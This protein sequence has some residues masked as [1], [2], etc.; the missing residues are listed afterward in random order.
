MQPDTVEI[1]AARAKHALAFFYAVI[2]QH[3]SG[4]FKCREGKMSV[5][6]AKAGAIII[7]AVRQGRLQR[8][9]V[10]RKAKGR[11]KY[12]KNQISSA[13]EALLSEKLTEEEADALKSEGFNFKNPTRR[14]RILAALYKKACGGD[15][16]AIKEL[17]V[18]ISDTENEA[19]E[20]VVII[21]DVGKKNI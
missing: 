2:I 15:L 20:P 7:A 8:P 12:V 14:T 1:E 11:R 5:N 19:A 4:N 18:L 16:S 17:A 21:D 9:C 6:V 3:K 13:A 10:Y